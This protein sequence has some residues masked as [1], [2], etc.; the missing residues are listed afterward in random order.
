MSFK[1]KLSTAKK[2]WPIALIFVMTGLAVWAASRYLTGRT[3]EVE[4]RLAD[5]AAKTL[6][7]VV[8]PM[9][10]LNAG[11]ELNLGVLVTR[12]IPKEYVNQDAVTQETVE[13]LIGKKLTRA[14]T[15]GTPLLRS[16][17]ASYEFKP[18]SLSLEAGTRAI[19]IPV[20]EINSVSGMLTAGDKIDIL[21][22]T[23]AGA[24]LDGG[25]SEMQLLPLL[26]GVVV[27]ATG[28]TTQRELI[29]QTEQGSGRQSGSRSGSYNTVT[30]AVPP[31]DA[32]RVVLAQQM[33]RIIA[34]LRR[35]DDAAL[36][37]ELLSA[38]DVFGPK[39][40]TPTKQPDT[41]AYIVGGSFATG[42]QGMLAQAGQGAPG[43]VN[44]DI[45]KKLMSTM[46]RGQQ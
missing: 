6:V 21:V 11:E 10:D 43:G 29:A 31:R 16:F 35:P 44:A 40:T 39:N 22:M 32:Q 18:F 19:T 3:A 30:I 2:F 46:A 28:T 8:V 36:S 45:M 5:K 4:E 20:D 14:V 25:K 23:Q 1:S 34:L 13:G 17:I 33:G 27:R 42:S 12:Q 41:I 37:N 24:A 15:R 7:T 9:R 26:Q 38:S